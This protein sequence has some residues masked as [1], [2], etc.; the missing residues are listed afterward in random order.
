MKISLAEL[1]WQIQVLGSCC[2]LSCI[3]L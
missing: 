1:L 3:Y 2:K